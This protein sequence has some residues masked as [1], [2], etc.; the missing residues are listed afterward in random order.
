[1]RQQ[2]TLL[3]CTSD[4][5]ST[6]ATTF[7][8][9]SYRSCTN[10]HLPR[11][12]L[13]SCSTNYLPA[14]ATFLQQQLPSCTSDYQSYNSSYQ[15]CTNPDIQ[16]LPVLHQ[17]SIFTPTTRS[18]TNN[19]NKIWLFETTTTFCHSS[20]VCCQSLIF[21]KFVGSIYFSAPQYMFA[22]FT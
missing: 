6:A 2:D 11:Q 12:Q 5:L 9:S 13:P 8:T 21:Q 22:C 14:A 15:S 7:C 4:H 17:Q 10:D 3:S 20:L 16:Q 18:C 1:M 19:H